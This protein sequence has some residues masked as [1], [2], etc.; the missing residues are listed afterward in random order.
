MNA[1]GRAFAW[2]GGHAVSRTTRLAEFSPRRRT[3]RARA[4][5]QR[6]LADGSTLGPGYYRCRADGQRHHRDRAAHTR[7]RADR[8]DTR[9]RALIIGGDAL[10]AAPSRSPGR[11]PCRSCLWPT[12]SWL[13]SG[14]FSRRPLPRSRLASSAGKAR[15]EACPQRRLRP[16]RQSF[17][18]RHRRSRRHRILLQ[19]VFYLVPCFAA[20]TTI[21]VLAIPAHAI[22]HERAR[23][24]DQRGTSEA[25][26]SGWRVLLTRRPLLI[27]AAPPPSS[28]SPMRPCSPS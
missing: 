2:Q 24:F 21:A 20:L 4:V 22:D 9:K 28:T 3:R 1:S 13:S 27:L 19:T 17:D 11:R 14:P 18:R 15:R 10:S 5:R 7:R 16:R 26:P 25:H 12:L 23:G 6:V 8:C